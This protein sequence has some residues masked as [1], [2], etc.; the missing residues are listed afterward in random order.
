MT[1]RQQCVAWLKANADTLMDDDGLGEATKLRDAVGVENWGSYI[2][3]MQ[4]Q[5]SPEI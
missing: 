3:D 4:V 5:P 1:V 2:A